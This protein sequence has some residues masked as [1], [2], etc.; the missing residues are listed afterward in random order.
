MKK[1]KRGERE[2][3]KERDIYIHKHIIY[4]L[5]L[6]ILLSP[7]VLH[8][9]TIIMEIVGWGYPPGIKDDMKSIYVKKKDMPDYI[10]TGLGVPFNFKHPEQENSYRAGVVNSTTLDPET[11]AM[12]IKAKFDNTMNGWEAYEN[13]VSGRY[14]QLSVGNNFQLDLQTA[15]SYGHKIN[16]IS[17]V[18]QGDNEKGV[19]FATT[20][21]AVTKPSEKLIEMRDFLLKYITGGGEHE[22]E[23]LDDSSYNKNDNVSDEWYWNTNVDDNNDK[24]KP[25]MS[26]PKNTRAST[27]TINNNSTSSTPQTPFDN[28]LTV[29]KS[30]EK[31]GRD[32]TTDDLLKLE[33]TIR[34]Q[35]KEDKPRDNSKNPVSLQARLEELERENAEQKRELHSNRKRAREDEEEKYASRKKAVASIMARILTP[36]DKIKWDSFSENMFTPCKDTDVLNSA[37]KQTIAMTSLAVEKLEDSMS[38][39][40]NYRALLEQK[41]KEND[42]LVKE[43]TIFAQRT[44]ISRALEKNSVDFSSPTS[45]FSNNTDNARSAELE[46]M[47]HHLPC[48]IK[49]RWW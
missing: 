39:L 30:Q 29:D 33:Q 40:E 47:A 18:K 3:E 25:R 35:I 17:I 15:D 23:T 5:L 11:G 45:R 37:Q 14:K 19:G 9:K 24:L 1:K 34:N 46:N 10:K 26:T 31:K 6:I 21:F 42:N 12:I 28:N 36:D 13:V 7:L 4:L 49:N 22:R 2:K 44:G 8:Q 16:E 32:F 38:E 27:T 20:I 48:G 43:N 41:I